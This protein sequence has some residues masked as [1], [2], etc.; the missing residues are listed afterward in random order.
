[1]P[2]QIETKFIKESVLLGTIGVSSINKYIIMQLKDNPNI[3][4]SE[5]LK[6]KIKKWI[7]NLNISSNEWCKGNRF[8]QFS[9]AS[10]VN[11]VAKILYDSYR[12]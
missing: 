10:G 4:S 3:D 8:S 7:Q 5:K 6:I 12:D 11:I 2:K 9:S 1:M